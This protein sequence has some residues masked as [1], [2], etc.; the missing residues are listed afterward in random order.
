M[1]RII[2]G[3]VGSGKTA[4]IVREMALNPSR[5]K[6]YANIVTHGLKDVVQIKRDMLMLKEHLRTK[7]DGTPVYKYSFNKA[8][9]QKTIKREG[10]INVV[11]DEA[12]TILN[13]RRAMSRSNLIMSDFLAMI[14]RIL[15]STSSGYGE[16]TL[17]SQL[18][19]RIDPIA[20]EM[21][22]NV[23]HCKCHF[24]KTCMD[25][26]HVW[27]EHNEVSEPR[28]T[29]P[30]CGSAT[31]QKFNHIIEVWHFSSMRSYDAWFEFGMKTYHSHYYIN[32]IESYFNKY[33]TLQWD[34]LFS[35]DEDEGE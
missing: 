33:N 32:D 8:F 13:A 28:W 24:Q 23:H 16:L 21:A 3:L 5:R 26:G 19:R 4:H 1:I 29:C 31:I 17:I 20:R 10:A 6:T 15:G 30:K 11:I 7:K 14:R 18:S 9:W 2:L 25:C 22:T 27:N 34:D 12:H 35:D